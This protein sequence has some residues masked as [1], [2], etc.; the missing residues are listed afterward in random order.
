MSKY[1][2]N[3]HIVS[4]ADGVS[5]RYRIKISIHCIIDA[6]FISSDSVGKGGISKMTSFITLFSYNM[7]PCFSQSMLNSLTEV[8]LIAMLSAIRFN[9]PP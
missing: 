6:I 5:V 3:T 1:L 8:P 4:S 2:T 9:A 7:L